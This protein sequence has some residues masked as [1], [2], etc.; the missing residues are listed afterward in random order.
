MEFSRGRAVLSV[1]SGRFWAM[2][3]VRRAHP[4][5]RDHYQEDPRRRSMRAIL[6]RAFFVYG[7]REARLP[8]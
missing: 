7:V 8:G 2:V 4:C 5:D 1:S 3:P 6:Q